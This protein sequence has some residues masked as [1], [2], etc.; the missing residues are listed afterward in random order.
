MKTYAPV[1]IYTL[2]RD[3]HFRR[4]VE[5][6]SRCTDADKTDV[7]IALDY[8]AK[9]SHRAGWERL[10]DYL[11]GEAFNEVKARFHNVILQERDENYGPARNFIAIRDCCYGMGHD[12]YIVSED[13]N[14]FSPNFLD[15]MNKGLTMFSDRDEIQAICGYTPV[16]LDKTYPHTAYS[17]YEYSAWGAGV[18]KRK[19]YKY[20]KEEVIAILKS[21]HKVWKIFRKEPRILYTLYRM[22]NINAPLY[23]D[24]CAVT[25]SILNDY[26]SI[27]PAKSLVRNWGNDGSGVNC[28]KVDDKKFIEQEIDNATKFDFDIEDIP[29]LDTRIVGKKASLSWK[30]KI[31]FPYQMLRFYATHK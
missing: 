23:G 22:I 13:D 21:W 8:P 14:E 15:Y 24:T 18:W 25:R 12:R 30:Q 17:S 19:F 2:C 31:K 11:H 6:L 9:E 10:K 7:F 5:S 4:C 16:T 3:V 26:H 27:F 1:I 28:Y 20:N 29:E